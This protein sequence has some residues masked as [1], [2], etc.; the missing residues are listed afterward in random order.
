MA[1]GFSAIA[2]FAQQASYELPATLSNYGT[3]TSEEGVPYPAANYVTDNPLNDGAYI[4]VPV[5]SKIMY[6][7]SSTGTPSAY[8]WEVPG[9][10]TDDDTAQDLIVTYSTAGTYDFPTLTATYDSSNDVFSHQLKIK[11]GGHAE[12]CHSDTREYYTTYGLGSIQYNPTTD[13]W[14]GGSNKVEIAGVGNFYKFSSGDMYVDAV[15][16]YVD[17]KPE[18]F[19]DDAT[20]KAR[21]YL[22]YITDDSF[23]MMGLYGYLG[24]LEGDNIP[25]DNCKTAADGVFVPTSNAGVYR[26]D[27]VTPMSCTG[28]PYLFF[29]VEGFFCGDMNTA[30]VDED[31]ALLADV[32]P[33]RTLSTDEYTNA[34]AH[35]SFVR[36]SSESDYLRPVS[37]FGGSTMASDL[38]GWK[39]YSFWI[40]PVVRGAETPF[41]GIGSVSAEDKGSTLT[42]NISGEQLTVTG[43]ADGT[44]DIYG[45]NGARQLSAQAANGG[46]VFN[47]SALAPGVYII[48]TTDGA[49]A[50]FVK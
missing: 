17:H 40:C 22:P 39:T 10:T 38:S 27:C 33:Y 35:N 29:A 1:A 30:S 47:T 9:G 31:F 20:V 42:L 44:V 7:N 5:G 37:M 34:L 12:L 6:R 28:Y 15:N 46:A 26:M 2:I 23:S 36:Q 43:A 50:K 25:M 8:S 41:A 24:P 19:A 16:I 21:V 49:T 3:I 13:G 48:R 32:T 14:L 45:I 4:W 11:V 18:K